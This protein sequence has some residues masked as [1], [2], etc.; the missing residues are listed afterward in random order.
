MLTPALASASSG[1]A[2]PSFVEETWTHALSTLRSRLDELVAHRD[3][4]VH[5]AVYRGL[6]VRE[7]GDWN[8][9]ATKVT[10]LATALTS[11]LARDVLRRRAMYDDELTFCQACQC[12]RFV[13]WEQR[14]SRPCPCRR[15]VWA[16]AR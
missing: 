1:G 4:F 5:A 15:R 2:L 8:I 12:Y 16:I 7:A 10:D 11:L 3:G 14:P 13:H 9:D 6:L